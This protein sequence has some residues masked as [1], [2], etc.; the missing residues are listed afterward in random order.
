M[1]IPGSLLHIRFSGPY[2]FEKKL[3]DTDYVICTPDRRCRSCVCHVKSYAVWFQE[4]QS[5]LEEV[6]CVVAVSVVSTCPVDD[7]L[8][9][10]NAPGIGAL[11][12]SQVQI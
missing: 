10:E 7:C 5:T 4:G 2:G 1:P 8:T 12:N 3:S 9:S 6:R 11:Q